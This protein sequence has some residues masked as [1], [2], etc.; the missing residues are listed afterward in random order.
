MPRGE[1]PNSRANLKPFS[2]RTEKEQREI[3]SAGGKASGETRSLNASLRA[4]CTPDV[5]D[6]LN[7]RVLSMAKHGNLKAYEL[8]RDGL[9]E[10]P[11]DTHD[12]NVGR[13][14]KLN[15]VFEQMGGKG[16]EE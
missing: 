5:M 2:V 7:R 1:H 16:L 10:K 4:M 3:R 12:I 6:D 13:S 15:D 8:I 11:T 14:E 9:G